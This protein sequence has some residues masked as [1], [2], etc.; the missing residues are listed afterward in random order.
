[1][2]RGMNNCR[3]YVVL[4]YIYIYIRNTFIHQ[5]AFQILLLSNISARVCSTVSS[6]NTADRLNIYLN[7]RTLQ[8]ET[9]RITST[10]PSLNRLR[11]RLT[12]LEH[13]Y[14]V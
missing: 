7:C 6:R 1:M 14:Y 10:N 2:I 11:I 5:Y 4:K 13:V 12:S 3:E 8:R 9:G